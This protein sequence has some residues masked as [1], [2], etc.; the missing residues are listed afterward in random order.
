MMD[1]HRLCELVDLQQYVARARRGSR[2]VRR[3]P[4]A[5]WRRPIVR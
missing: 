2:P 3:R 1:S 5:E 4:A